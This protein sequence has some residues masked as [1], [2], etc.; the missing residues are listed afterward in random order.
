M[1]EKV[2]SWRGFFL[3]VL[4][5]VMG[6][7][8][9]GIWSFFST[10]DDANDAFQDLFNRNYSIFALK[11][12]DKMEFAGEKVPLTYFDV[13]ESLDKELLVNTYVLF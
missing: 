9:I 3:P 1:K 11:L 7:L 2:L 5:I 13:R 10:R 6:I 4:L 8:S 12:P